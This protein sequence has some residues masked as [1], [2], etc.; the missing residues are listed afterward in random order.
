V[1][2]VAAGVAI[3]ASADQ[4]VQQAAF[5][6]QSR[7]GQKAEVQAKK[8]GNEAEVPAHY[9]RQSNPWDGFINEHGDVDWD[10]GSGH[11]RFDNNIKR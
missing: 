5:V 1:G 9:L 2:Q 7:A 4:R 3:P 8:V 10:D 6:G 11:R